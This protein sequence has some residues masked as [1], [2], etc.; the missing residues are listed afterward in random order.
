MYLIKVHKNY[1]IKF[2]EISQF[3]LEMSDNFRE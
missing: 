1:S 3:V 2:D